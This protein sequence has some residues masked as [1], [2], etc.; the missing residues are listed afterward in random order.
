M[1]FGSI[2]HFH[3][4][5]GLGPKFLSHSRLWRLGGSP[6]GPG[7]GDEPPLRPLRPPLHPLRPRRHRCRPQPYAPQVHDHE[8][9]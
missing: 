5:N 4:V 3:R 8:H 7:L 9:N 6:A 1:H 2:L